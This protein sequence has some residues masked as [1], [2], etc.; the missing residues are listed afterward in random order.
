MATI[1]VSITESPFQLL[2]GIPSNI[3]LDTNVPST[4]F[5]TLDGSE[6]TVA[7]Y[8][9][10]GPIV[11]PSDKAY[12]IIRA[13]ATDGVDTSA[14]ITQ[15]YFTT[16]VGARHPHDKITGL[17]DGTGKATFPFGSPA[18]AFAVDHFGNTGGVIVN[19]PNLPQ[20]ADGYDGSGT[21]TG[22]GFFNPPRTQYQWLFSETNAIGERGRGLG[23][24]PARVI[25][26]K[27][28]ND[29]VQTI[30]SNT[31]RPLFNPRAL[32]IFQDSREEPYDPNIVNINRPY[33]DLEDQAK[34]RDGSMLT[35]IDAV[36]PMG[37]FL[38]QHYNATH[39]IMTYYYYDNR[40]CRWIIS[41]EPYTPSQNPTANMSGIVSRSSRGEGAGLVF[42]W[43]PF[44]YRC[45]I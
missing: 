36:T 26:V 27:P 43:V 8:V 6:P 33:F 23:T 18:E 7:S 5:Y 13:F 42:K 3:T 41:K 12:A 9:A 30:S 2:A 14:V 19:D 10:V 11:L 17:S 37:G 21:N 24:L 16:V 20:M 39:N 15:E 22:A 40:V 34:A 38:K 31:S 4:I 1:T 28:R 29:N 32:V 44:K 25:S 35:N 45:L